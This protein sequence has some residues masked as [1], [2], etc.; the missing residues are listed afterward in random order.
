MVFIC[1]NVLVLMVQHYDQP[2]WLDQAS[3]YANYVFTAFFL[4]EMSIKLTGIGWLA[5]FTDGMNC[6]DALVVVMSVIEIIVS[7]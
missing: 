5:Y 4:A 2:A 7:R 3:T 6:F 1:S